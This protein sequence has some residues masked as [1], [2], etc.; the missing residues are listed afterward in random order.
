MAAFD[1]QKMAKEAEEECEKLQRAMDRH[2][3]EGKNAGDNWAAWDRKRQ[4]LE[5]MYW[6][7]FENRREFTRRAER[8]ENA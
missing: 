4:V 1:Y 5:Q 3:T 2:K 6:E 8:R 7:Q